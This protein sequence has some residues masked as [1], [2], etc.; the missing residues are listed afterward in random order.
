MLITGTIT[1]SE[2]AGSKKKK[3]KQKQEEGDT[4]KMKEILKYGGVSVH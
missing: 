1:S 4:Q 2:T 3:H